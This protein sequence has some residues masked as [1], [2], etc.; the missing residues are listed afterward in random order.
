MFGLGGTKYLAI[1]GTQPDDITDWIADFG[2]ATYGIAR[3]Q[4]VD[5][6]RYWRKLTTPAGSP[7]LY[8]QQEINFL[9]GLT[10]A[11]LSPVSNI[12]SYTQ[13]LASLNTDRGLGVLGASE[14]VVV[15]G[16]SLGGH[17]A[18]MFA[19]M[20]PMAVESLYTF[21]GA[22]VGGIGVELLDRFIRSGG[23]ASA[24]LE[25]GVVNVAA[26]YG[27][28]F[29]AGVG[30]LLGNELRI[31][32]EKSLF[33][34]NNHLIP[35]LTNS[36]ALY[37]LIGTLSPTLPVSVITEILDGASNIPSLS[38][39]TALDQLRSLFAIGGTTPTPTAVQ[40][41]EQYFENL[42]ALHAVA[43]NASQSFS[44]ESL[45]S[46]PAATIKSGALAQGGAAIRFALDRLLPFS[47]K[48]ID[49]TAIP[50]SQSLDV[51]SDDERSGRFTLPWIE[52]RSELL[53]WLLARN[54]KDAATVLQRNDGGDSIDFT[55]YSP[56]NSRETLRVVRNLGAAPS[57]SIQ[58]FF[59]GDNAD[60]FQGY[61]K[62]DRLY[63][64]T[65]DDLLEG[66]GG[67]DR[68]QGDD[69]ADR[70]FGGSGNDVLVG[71]P[72][73]DVIEGGPGRDRLEG[74][75]GFDTYV[76]T[77]ADGHDVIHDV[78]RLG[79]IMLDGVQIAGGTGADGLFWNSEHTIAYSFSGDLADTGTL[80]IAGSVVVE[81]FHNG[82]FGITL[83]DVGS[84][85][86][87][88]PLAGG[89]RMYLDRPYTP[90][91]IARREADNEYI[92]E[93]KWG[94]PFNDTFIA[95]PEMGPFFTGRGG[96][97]LLEGGYGY[98]SL[99]GGAG[100]DYLIN[101]E[102]GAGQQGPNDIHYLGGGAGRDTLVGGNEADTLFGD[103]YAVRAELSGTD[104]RLVIDNGAWRISGDP[105]TAR[106]IGGVPVGWFSEDQALDWWRDAAP[107]FEAYL[108]LVVGTPDP[109][110]LATYYDDVIDGGDGNDT[111]VGGAGSDQLQGGPGN[112]R[113]FGDYPVAL[114]QAMV[115]RWQ[116]I[117]LDGLESFAELFGRAGNDELAGGDGDD[118]LYDSEGEYTVATGGSGNDRMDFRGL[119]EYVN[120]DGG[121]GNDSMDIRTESAFLVGGEGNDR[122]TFW[123]E[124]SAVIEGDAGNDQLWSHGEWSELNGGEGDDALIAAGWSVVDGGA[125]SDRYFISGDAEGWHT[126]STDDP[127]GNDFDRLIIPHRPENYDVL[128]EGNDLIIVTNET[129]E[130]SGPGFFAGINPAALPL[131]DV[132]ALLGAIDPGTP[133]FVFLSPVEPPPIG[134]P[135]AI[136]VTNWFEGDRYKFDSVQF[137]ATGAV[138]TAQDLEEAIDVMQSGYLEVAVALDSSTDPWDSLLTLP[139]FADSAESTEDVPPESQDANLGGSD[140]QTTASDSTTD[141]ASDTATDAPSTSAAEAVATA[142]ATQVATSLSA[143]SASTAAPAQAATGTP[144][145]SVSA[146]VPSVAPS[147]EAAGT[148]APTETPSTAT[149][150]VNPGTPAEPVELASF[151]SM[152]NPV[153]PV[154]A[155]N[156]AERQFQPQESPVEHVASTNAV[157]EAFFARI[158]PPPMRTQDWLDQWFPAGARSVGTAPRTSQE[159]SPVFSEP[160]FPVLQE[161]LPME[162]E[163]LSPDEISRRYEEIDAWLASHDGSEEQIAG[164]AGSLCLGSFAFFGDSFSESGGTPAASLFGVTGGLAALG[165]HT[166]RPFAGLQEGW[167]RLG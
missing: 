95:G 34:A 18:Q 151:S 123:G 38:L 41:R 89:A 6:Y 115:P 109:A 63:G 64:S 81:N 19:Q 23:G 45:V 71:G 10:Q 122:I 117:S 50:A 25:G 27:F 157:I 44:I 59:G 75:P 131:E 119:R 120:A 20:F 72:G 22:G 82:D 62:N 130:P 29:T 48:G 39:E 7:V 134:P 37:D 35:E 167:A 55:W 4:T 103:F 42:L 113:I 106:E 114:N 65:G 78:D 127:T 150:A 159:T 66:Q 102:A 51:I 125:G 9:A 11:S 21:N 104:A 16:H 154:N 3:A 155:R 124:G 56:S 116:G 87:A 76:L 137:G 140:E 14:R 100:D 31:F 147:T 101:H 135:F 96:N 70:L 144:V 164:G 84:G 152:P 160:D 53:S 85:P 142:A 57:Q 60:V 88:P 69:G 108:G 33:P 121:P 5:L 46:M 129:L 118:Y 15:V 52:D 158:E 80:S 91:E 40:N 92:Y 98:A 165:G 1:R 146:S 94:S 110:S 112:D 97:D 67:D 128:R 156:E 26:K 93:Y 111:I 79:K 126:V 133:V 153:I 47:V 2:I 36:L 28:D 54:M 24:A 30:V 163:S 107:T 32:N 12:T 161:P 86:A 68:L 58:V 132:I 143:D 105:P 149:P 49:Y 138:W 145:D 74:G 43:A 77:S 83:N 136:T 17:L 99:W 13:L 162:G 90:E 141:Q 61:G 148:V 166:M 139:D 8:S 73:D